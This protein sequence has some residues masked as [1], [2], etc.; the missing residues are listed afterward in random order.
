MAVDSQ[1]D[2][3]IGVGW[4][5][6]ECDFNEVAFGIWRKEAL[7]CVTLLCGQDH[8]YTVHFMTGIP[9]AEPRDVLTDVGV[10]TAAGLSAS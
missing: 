2:A 8:P 10:L 4:R 7:K 5:V 3:L 1:I 9:K 6:L